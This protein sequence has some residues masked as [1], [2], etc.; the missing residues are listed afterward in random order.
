MGTQRSGSRDRDRT[1]EILWGDEETVVETETGPEGPVTEPRRRRRR[2]H[3]PRWEG[4]K[5]F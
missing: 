4:R 2:T 3:V 1:S 5:R